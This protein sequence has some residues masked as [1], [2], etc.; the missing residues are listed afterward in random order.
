MQ[1]IRL[2]PHCVRKSHIPQRLNSSHC[3]QLPGIAVPTRHF[4][5]PDLKLTKIISLQEIAPWPGHGTQ[6]QES[7]TETLKLTQVWDSAQCTNTGLTTTW[8]ISSTFGN[9]WPKSSQTAG[10]TPA[11]TKRLLQVLNSS[12]CLY[13]AQG[14][15]LTI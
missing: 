9:L 8:R 5:E 13:E 15:T 1:F 12:S 2:G 10:C 11:V 14:S 7:E 4:G 3:A 6:Q